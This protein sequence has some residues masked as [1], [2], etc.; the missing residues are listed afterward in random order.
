MAEFA[1]V[2]KQW[3]RMCDSMQGGIAKCD[4]CPLFK[5]LCQYKPNEKVNF[6]EAEKIITDWAA[7]H[8][9]PVYPTWWE[10]LAANGVVPEKVV[11][12]VAAL[13]AETGLVEHVS[14]DKAKRLGIMPK[15]VEA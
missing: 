3:Q 1:W 12:E 8:P 13:I 14:E 2:M 11:P 5:A 7:A 4:S 15:V 10:W 9:E 6:A